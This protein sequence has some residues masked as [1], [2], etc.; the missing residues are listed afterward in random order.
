MKTRTWKTSRISLKNIF[1]NLSNFT[2]TFKWG[3]LCCDFQFTGSE[4]FLFKCLFWASDFLSWS[5]VSIFLSIKQHFI[6]SL[7]RR[8]SEGVRKSTF[9]HPHLDTKRTGLPYEPSDSYRPLKRKTAWTDRNIKTKTE[10]QIFALSLIFSHLLQVLR[11]CLEDHH[12]LWCPEI[13]TEEERC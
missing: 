10:Y 13:K 7:N 5:Q 11:R 3:D 6:T 8:E 2:K 1:K 9:K 12:D 4:G